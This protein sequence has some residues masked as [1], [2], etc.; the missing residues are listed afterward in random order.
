MDPMS[1]VLIISVEF[2]TL[3]PLFSII[4]RLYFDNELSNV[5]KTFADILDVLKKFQS[6]VIL[7]TTIFWISIVILVMHFMVHVTSNLGFIIINNDYSLF[8]WVSNLFLVYN[9]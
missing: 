7:K 2:V 3:G 1:I 6:E 5:L 8:D 9:E 4:W